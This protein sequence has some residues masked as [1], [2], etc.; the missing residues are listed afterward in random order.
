MVCSCA[1]GGG[2]G[3][4]AAARPPAQGDTDAG[5]DRRTRGQHLPRRHQLDHRAEFTF[6]NKY[7]GWTVG[8]RVGGR[9]YVAYPSGWSA[10]G[11]LRDELRRGSSGL[12]R[13]RGIGDQLHRV[14]AGLERRR[15]LRD[16]FSSRLPAGWSVGG[17]S[18]TNFIALP[19]GL[20]RGRR[21]GPPT[22][23]RFLQAGAS[24]ADR[25]RTS[26]RSLLGWTTGGRL[27]DQLRRLSNGT[28]LDGWRRL[29]PPISTALPPGWEAAGGGSATNFVA[30]PVRLARG[31]RGR[32][33]TSSPT[34]ARRLPPSR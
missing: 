29:P 4:P 22:T 1:R 8:G 16:Q 26:S 31:R 9:N 5:M 10:G 7:S 19:P 13:R 6:P 15:R 12:E 30:V 23:R 32:R 3:A 14:R 21:V 20:Q 24:A 2:A 33:P 27:G 28:R 25:R 11:W 17:G 18:A 34:L